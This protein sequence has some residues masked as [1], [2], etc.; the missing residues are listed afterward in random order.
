MKINILRIL[1]VLFPLFCYS[2]KQGN[3]W[4]FGNGNGIDFNSGEPVVILGGQTGTDAVLN[5]EGCSSISDSAGHLL[6][7]TGGK[8]IWNRN[9]QPMPNGSGLMGGTSSTQSSIIIPLPGSNSIYYVFTSDEFQGYDYPPQIQKG[10]RYSIV[11]ICLN[12]SLGD[13]LFYNKNILLLDSSTE[14]IAACQDA[15][16]NGYWIIGHKLFSDEFQAWHLVST[17][18][19]ETVT[20]HIGTIHG[21]EQSNLSWWNPTAQ[22]QMKLNPQGTKLALVIGNGEPAIIDLFDFNTTTGIISNFCHFVIDSGLGTIVYGVEFSPDGN[23]FYATFSGG[24]IGKHLYQFDITAGNGDC[25]AIKTSQTIIHQSSINSNSVMYG[26]Q[27]APNGKIYLV[28]NTSN[29]LSCINFPNLLG[30][31]CGYDSL[32]IELPEYNGHTLPCFI[33]GYKYHN[34]MSCT[35]YVILEPPD[36]SN[37]EVK[38][39]NVFSPNNDGVNDLFEIENLPEGTEVTI[40]SRW[41]ILLFDSFN[42]NIFWDGRTK[43]GTPVPDG[44]YYYVVKIPE[45]ET[46]KGFVELLK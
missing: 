14:K 17:G 4:H 46:K 39:P 29:D 9:H 1:L 40:Y 13:V 34:Q 25:E 5:Q 31:A 41:G 11:D 10:Y 28:G 8:T 18:I 38:I 33:A 24:S 20:T 26:M 12:D 36:T 45:S 44:I 43:G 16:G 15:S 42:S 32:A 23:K 19:S 30:L 21:W 3:I 27:I 37:K 7:Y 2:Q 22:G 35:D 6:F